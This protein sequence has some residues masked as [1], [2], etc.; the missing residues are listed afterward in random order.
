[1]SLGAESETILGVKVGVNGGCCVLCVLS[2]LG[3]RI[4]RQEVASHVT[5]SL[6]W[7]A[8]SLCSDD[9]AISE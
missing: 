7:T 4:K 6:L 8:V 1:M 5:G 2:H 9:D 3:N